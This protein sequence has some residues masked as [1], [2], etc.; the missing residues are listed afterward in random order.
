[1]N[2]LQTLLALA[3]LFRSLVHDE[4][5]GRRIR[6]ALIAR[7]R[8][9]TVP[10]AEEKQAKALLVTTVYYIREAD[11][12]ERASGPAGAPIGAADTVRAIAYLK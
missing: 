9:Q 6:A 10:G 7:S 3:V 8:W 11:E 5:S 4:E 12:R 1:M 2:S